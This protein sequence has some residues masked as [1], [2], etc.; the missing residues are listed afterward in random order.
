MP[1]P[2]AVVVLALARMLGHKDPSVTLRVHAGL[3]DTDLDVVAAS[4]HA[5]YSPK[6]RHETCS[7][8]RKR[9]DIGCAGGGTRTLTLSRARA[10]KARVSAN[11]TTPASPTSVPLTSLTN[12][13]VA[14]PTVDLLTAAKGL[15]NAIREGVR[16]RIGADSGR[17]KRLRD[18][19]S[20]RVA[21]K[22]SVRLAPQITNSS[23]EV[24]YITLLR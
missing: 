1:A 20:N 14:S 15:R 3:F 19:A 9:A 2:P 13:S 17:C 16:S 4:L 10:P 18:R 24:K 5:K 21:A 7:E 23:Q 6:S 11:S 12:L 22:D 8:L